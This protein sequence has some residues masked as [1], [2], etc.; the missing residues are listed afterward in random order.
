MSFH[1]VA[2][3]QRPRQPLVG[4]IEQILPGGR[5]TD[6][7]PVAQ[8]SNELIA[9]NDRSNLDDVREIRDQ[10]DD[11]CCDGDTSDTVGAN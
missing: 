9:A 6:A 8:L 4:A 10:L 7:S 11:F 5:I 1:A 3:L 2:V